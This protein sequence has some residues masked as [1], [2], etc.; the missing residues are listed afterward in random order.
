MTRKESLS[1]LLS[2]ERVGQGHKL[3]DDHQRNTHASTKGDDLL[4]DGVTESG[5]AIGLFVHKFGDR[6]VRHDFSS[7]FDKFAI[8]VTHQVGRDV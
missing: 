7:P 4:T 2:I 5:G 1:S 6:C 8:E 3:V